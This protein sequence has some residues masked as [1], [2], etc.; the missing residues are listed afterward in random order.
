[1]QAVRREHTG[2]E[3]A[4]RRALH[5]RGYRF[6]VHDR[7]LPGSPDIVFSLRRKAVFIHGCF[8][9]GHGCAKGRLPKSRGEYWVPK[10]EANKARDERA[11]SELRKAGWEALVVWQCQ[12]KDIEQVVETVISFLGPRRCNAGIVRVGGRE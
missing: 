5:A 10:I 8:W 4:I 2:P 7:T 3:M 11:L 9:H 12:V 6:R 1:M